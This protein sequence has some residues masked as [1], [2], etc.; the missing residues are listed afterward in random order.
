[1]PIQITGISTRIFNPNSRNFVEF[2]NFSGNCEG[3]SRML[4]NFGVLFLW[5]C[6]L[7]TKYKA[8]TQKQ[9]LNIWCEDVNR[10]QRNRK[11]MYIQIHSSTSVPCMPRTV[12]K[13]VMSRCGQLNQINLWL[14]SLGP[15]LLKIRLFVASVLC[16]LL[17]YGLWVMR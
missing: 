2:T 15:T 10:R 11:R 7:L 3:F 13:C 17:C 16:S 8:E 4:T 1:M 12:Y 5:I 14:T 6:K 9:R